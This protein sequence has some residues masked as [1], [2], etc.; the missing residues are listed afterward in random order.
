MK[1]FYNSGGSPNEEGETTL[2]GMIMDGKTMKVGAV[3]GLR[4][5]KEA[6]SVARHVFDY[7]KHTLLVGDQATEFA[8]K[9]GFQKQTLSTPFN[10][11][12][13]NEWKNRNCQPNYWQNVLPLPET[14][15]GPYEKVKLSE[16]K[17]ET[18]SVV[19]P[20]DSQNHDTIGMVVIDW[21]G[22]VA[23]GTS[24]N[25]LTYKIPGRVGDSP[26]PVSE[27]DDQFFNAT[28]FFF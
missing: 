9:M 1:I 18:P 8:V 6:I 19:S 12:L 28:N 13:I 26:I 20:V 2:D 5:I 3:A 10:E 15:C 11:E 14:T 23:A 4:Y 16:V 17:N 22:N 25:G 7:T 21:N 24:T 27:S